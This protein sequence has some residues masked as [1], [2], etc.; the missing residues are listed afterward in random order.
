MSGWLSPHHWHYLPRSRLFAM[1]HE[2][3]FHSLWFVVRGQR[4]CPSQ[5]IVKSRFN[6][7]ELK[8]AIREKG[9]QKFSG[10]QMVLWKV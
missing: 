10:T 9:F 4:I 8:E 1:Q 3:K 5:V 6:I 7:D 2:E